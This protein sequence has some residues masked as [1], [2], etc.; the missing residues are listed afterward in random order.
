MPHNSTSD[1]RK[2]A[3]TQKL[4]AKEA[5]E[6]VRR[7]ADYNHK[8]PKLYIIYLMMI[9]TLVY[10]TDEVSSNITNALQS[11]IVVEFFVDKALVSGT[12]AFNEAYNKGL[13]QFSFYTMLFQGTVVFSFFYKTL[14]DKFG[15]KPFLVINT[16]GMALGMLVCFL[17]QNLFLFLTGTLIITFFIPN[18]MQVV[19]ILETAPEKKRGTIY[20]LIKGL[21]SLGISLIPLMRMAFMGSDATQWR[22]VFLVPAILGF[23][24]CFFALLFAGETDVFLRRRIDYLKKTPEQREEEKKTK[25]EADKNA[26]GGLGHALKFAFS[27]KQ[28]KWLFIAVAIFLVGAISTQDYESIM[29]ADTMTTAQINSA[30]L[31][32]PFG[33]A[34]VTLIYGFFSDKFGRKSVS[35]SMSGVATICFIF[36][37]LS[38][39][40]LWS[41]Y[42]VGT[43]I[44]LFVGSFWAVSDTLGI[45]STESCPTNLRASMLSA[46]TVMAGIGMGT[47]MITTMGILYIFPTIRLDYWCLGVSVPAMVIGL[48][49]LCF[50]VG[51]TKGMNMDQ[52]TGAEWD[53]KQ[54]QD[55]A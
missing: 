35:V 10:I 28:L 7:E 48:L 31:M 27:H 21:A 41:P 13:A 39:K 24:A 44:G 26:Q 1:E 22:K 55:K 30:L 42:L 52:V 38:A 11:S 17:Q 54:I 15:R 8:R 36:F 50:K 47:I 46:E 19:Y 34:F 49:I 9:I 40:F 18:D 25:T 2:A 5:K 51:E 29:K 53:E 33:V 43:F 20:S 16:L 45:M 14:A 23:V 32:Y 12:A 6:L 37:I 4:A 3:K